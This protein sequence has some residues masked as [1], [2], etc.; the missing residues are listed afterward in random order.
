MLKKK[1]KASR[2]GESLL[3]HVYS[4]HTKEFIS[5]GQCIITPGFSLVSI[6]WSWNR[7]S[8][9]N[10]P[11]LQC[12]LHTARYTSSSS[13]EMF[14]MFPHTSQYLQPLE[15]PR[16][17]RTPVHRQLIQLLLLE[18]PQNANCK[19]DADKS[20]WFISF[21]LRTSS[22]YNHPFSSGLGRDGRGSF[23][24]SMLC[25]GS[26]HAVY[27]DAKHPLSK[28]G[29]QGSSL[30]CE[31]LM[32]SLHWYLL[33]LSHGC[34]AGRQML[35]LRQRCFPP[36][37]NVCL[38]VRWTSM[39]CQGFSMLITYWYPQTEA[40]FVCLPPRGPK[41]APADSL[42]THRMTTRSVSLWNL[43]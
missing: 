5:R 40:Q 32:F 4:L 34:T 41:I 22:L 24:F 31:M 23:A 11:L 20:S 39:N 26:S 25:T 3:K 12:K 18:H 27:E 29:N 1:G 2:L 21:G 28:K 36:M 38:D 10:L 33:R 8:N 19:H 6:I 15:H 7:T 16:D 13:S 9:R 35:Q 37:D 43:R 42:W 14:L 17:I 30:L